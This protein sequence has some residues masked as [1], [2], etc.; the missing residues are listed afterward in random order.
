MGKEG[1][2]LAPEF[3]WYNKPTLEGKAL[4]LVEEIIRHKTNY[5][6]LT[7]LH[8]EA[9]IAT[10][11]IIICVI[12]EE[13]LDVW[14][15]TKVITNDTGV[16]ELIILAVKGTGVFKFGSRLLAA[17]YEIAQHHGCQFIW[18]QTSDPAVGRVLE[19]YKFMPLSMSYVHSVPLGKRQ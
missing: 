15:A 7:K 14:F 8:I 13:G 6:G 1:L 4:D 17:W 11:E 5:V 2:S 12:E 9:A 10:G 16:K 3:Y 18:T 19:K